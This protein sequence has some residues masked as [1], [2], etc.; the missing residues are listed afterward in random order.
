MNLIDDRTDFDD[1]SADVAENIDEVCDRF[2]REWKSGNAP[3]IEN[4]LA[5]VES[6][7]RAVLL[8]ELLRV[9]LAYLHKSGQLIVE[10]EYLVRFP[11]LNTEWLRRAIQR[12]KPKRETLAGVLGDFQLQ[13]EIGRGGMGVV[14]AAMQ[15]SLN[16]R[17]AVKV[18]PS[19]SMSDSRHLRRFQNESRAA[20]SLHHPHIVPVFAVG[21]DRGVN[22][23]AM[24]LIDGQTLSQRIK[25]IGSSE[26]SRTVMSRSTG[27]SS[28]VSQSA[29]TGSATL[30]VPPNPTALSIEQYREIARQG[31]QVAQALEHAHSIG[32]VHRDIKPSNLLIDRAGKMWVTDFGLARIANDLSMTMTGDVLGTLRYMSPEQALAKHGLVDHRTDIYSLGVTLYELLT[33]RPAIDGKDRGEILH[34]LA[35]EEPPE[36][37]RINPHIPLDLETIV[38]KAIAKEPHLRYQSAEEFADDLRRFADDQP[39]KAR[40]QTRWQSFVRWQ[41]R[42]RALSAALALTI[43]VIIV[44]NLL[45]TWKWREER[46]AHSDARLA[47]NSAKRSERQ[48]REAEQAAREAENL[49]KDAEQ[50]ATQRAEELQRSVYLQQIARAEQEWWSNNVGRARQILERCP[51]EMRHW[52]WGYLNRLCNSELCS[53]AAQGRLLAVAF[54][55][56]GRT[57][58]AGG[59]SGTIHL[60]DINTGAEQKLSGHTTLIQS[61]VFSSDG[62]RL[63]SVASYWGNAIPGEVKVWDV[64]TRQELLTLPIA[65]G[66]NA[67]DISFSPDQRS[68]AIPL[69]NHKVQLVDLET[70]AV[71]ELIGQGS[72]IKSVAFSPDGKTVVAG[73]SNGKIV[74]WDAA[75][76]NFTKT[77]SGHTG[78]VMSLSFHPDG[79]RLASAGWDH[80]LRVWDF[81]LPADA[82]PRVLSDHTGIVN[83]VEFSPDGTQLASASEDGGIMIW[84]TKSWKSTATLRGHDSLVQSIS[85]GPTGKTLASAARD[86]YVKVW[87]LTRSQ[88][89]VTG[90]GPVG[91][92]RQVA[93][94]VNGARLIVPTFAIAAHAGS[95]RVLATVD[96]QTG[97]QLSVMARRP[98]GF[99]T[100]A[101]DPAGEYVAADAEHDILL[102]DANTEKPLRELKGHASR[103]T[104][105]TALAGGV[106]VS[107]DETGTVKLWQATTGQL[108]REL[109][110]QVGP[111]TTMAALAEAQLFAVAGREGQLSA[112]RWTTSGLEELTAIRQT[113]GPVVRSLACCAV[114][115][116]LVAGGEDGVIRRWNLSTGLA[117]PD[118][119]GHT[120]AVVSMGFTPDGRR[121]ASGGQDGVIVLWETQ[122]GQ[123]ALTLRRQFRELFGIAFSPDGQK[124][125]AVSEGR[126]IRIWDSAPQTT[127]ERATNL[128][129]WHRSEAVAAASQRRWNLAMSHLDPLIEMSPLDGNPFAEPN[130]T[131]SDFRLRGNCRVE[132]SQ[133]KAAMADFARACELG[134]TNLDHWSCRAAACLGAGDL[135]EHRRVVASMFQ[136]FEKTQSVGIAN[137][138]LYITAPCAQP[139]A[140]RDELL[141]LADLAVKAL[142]GN[143]RLVGAVRYRVGDFSGALDAFA[144][145]APKFGPRA[146]DWCFQAMCRHQLGDS[147]TAAEH[148]KQCDAW[149]EAAERHRLDGTK[150]SARWMHWQERAEVLQLREEATKLLNP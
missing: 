133:W 86:G 126:G 135:D 121:L 113:A 32:I 98:N 63:A 97:R 47:E 44:A 116:T 78:D 141:R 149:I 11:T 28:V 91:S 76:G 72:S 89:G 38:L 150:T 134:P 59:L 105:L 25:S 143:E 64:I 106:L 144:I 90:V 125:A 68:V 137:S 60:W 94:R 132:L 54:S 36:P 145:A 93:F 21:S 30:P 107:A 109:D 50:R 58:A 66:T 34:K 88:L 129:A 41:R 82:N 62:Q 85:F 79:K 29:P 40:R 111:V 22:F 77:L 27:D 117:L 115:K 114:G 57:I 55:P 127:A 46:L 42:N 26:F 80:T 95:D 39:I 71:R 49:A 84:D 87:D 20:A 56:D 61:V 37:R 52:E 83:D 118:I 18:L 139:P 102:W 147:A 69:W 4:F 100:V 108:L 16:R 130:A 17:V 14:Y 146:W 124:L 8:Q 128:A 53:F 13:Y 119:K 43:A 3:R 65:K 19:S 101:V 131:A 138:M 48:A 33:L 74:A 148:L 1:V 96:P 35:F 15:V 140:D 75:T 5:E 6:D 81:T 31:M 99:Q 10:D 9:E 136:Q 7:Q 70:K 45:I 142:S 73:G 51:P 123:E 23:F 120:S 2:E 92:Y 110:P 122:T 67:T 24:Q 12:S 103:I 104:S 112:W